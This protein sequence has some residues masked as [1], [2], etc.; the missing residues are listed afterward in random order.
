MEERDTIKNTLTVARDKKIY[1]D[2]RKNDFFVEMIE[3]IYHKPNSSAIDPE[4][5]I[6]SMSKN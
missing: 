1:K 4:I 6:A 3:Q 2:L 5:A